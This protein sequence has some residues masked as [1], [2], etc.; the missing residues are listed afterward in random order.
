MGTKKDSE[1]VHSDAVR[2]ARVPQ[3][4]QARPAKERAAAET[5]ILTFSKWLEEHYAELLPPG[6]GDAYQRSSVHPSCRCRP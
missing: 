2:Q 4:W 1:A 3:F 6:P 5:G